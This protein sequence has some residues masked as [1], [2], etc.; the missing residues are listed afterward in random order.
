MQW[1]NSIHCSTFRQKQ[2]NKTIKC[3][4]IFTALSIR[5][6]IESTY[7]CAETRNK[8][9]CIN[10]RIGYKKAIYKFT[11]YN[12]RPDVPSNMIVVVPSRI[13]ILIDGIETAKERCTVVVETYVLSQLTYVGKTFFGFGEKLLQ[14]SIF[15]AYIHTLTSTYGVLFK[16][17]F[18]WWCNLCTLK[19]RMIHGTSN[20]YVMCVVCWTLP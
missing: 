8:N 11:K 12:S 15:F 20:T 14:K 3:H 9:H 2:N 16:G 5:R 18:L 13:I 4:C 7:A 10:T 6:W 17:D 19:S 1:Q